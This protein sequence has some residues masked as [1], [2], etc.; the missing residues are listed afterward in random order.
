VSYVFHL[1]IPYNK[2]TFCKVNNFCL[3]RET[4]WRKFITST[5]G[6]R[7]FEGEG[8]MWGGE[9]NEWRYFLAS[10]AQGQSTTCVY[11]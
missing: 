6:K 3:N 4:M 10:Q 2:K 5:L 11:R 9:V 1:Y 8:K 7:N